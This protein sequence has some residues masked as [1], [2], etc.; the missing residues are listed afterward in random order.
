MTYTTVKFER[1]KGFGLITLNRPSVG[2]AID[3]QMAL[4][5]KE[6]CCQLNQYDDLSAVVIEGGGC[7]CS[8]EDP[9][10]Y[11]G[12]AVEYFL[13]NCDVAQALVG[14][15]IPVIAAIDGDAMGIG[16]ALVLACDIR[17]ASQAARFSVATPSHDQLLPT[18]IT[19]LL[20]RVVGRGRALEMLLLAHTV[21]AEEALR[22]G[23]VHRLVPSGD[24]L[25]QAVELA[26]KMASKSTI[27]LKYA[28][29][30][31]C[32]GLDLT[33]DQGMR[34]ECDMYMIIHTTHDRTEGI[35]AFLEKRPP[36]FS[37]A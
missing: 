4:E 20:P 12:D 24:V 1:K 23:L 2:N 7:F 29:E 10:E 13:S 30:T 36:N 14:V 15:D 32:K 9:K 6:L 33:L 17:I 31:V 18:G 28:K 8:G 22:I 3:L 27:S 21:D 11:Q 19:Q 16:L 37:G 35:R 34:L 25:N 26:E 5:L